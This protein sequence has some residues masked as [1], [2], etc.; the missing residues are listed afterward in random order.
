MKG[1]CFR[2]INGG[3]EKFQIMKQGQ[4]PTVQHQLSMGTNAWEQN[5][6]PSQYQTQKQ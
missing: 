6:G 5:Q 2:M 3:E 1:D 4:G